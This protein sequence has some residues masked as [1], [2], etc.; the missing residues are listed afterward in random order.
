MKSVHNWNNNQV[1]SLYQAILKLK[2]LDEAKSFFRD[3]C[4]R[5]ELIEMA[6]RWE[7]AKLIDQGQPYRKIAEKTGLSTTTVARVSE[8]L[9]HGKGGYKLI[10]DRS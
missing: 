9:R 10:L 3:L 1:N 5:E 7:A 6:K 8:W 4:T 2:S